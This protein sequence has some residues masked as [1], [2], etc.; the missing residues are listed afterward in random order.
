MLSPGS[1]RLAKQHSIPAMPVPVRAIVNS[2]LVP[3]TVRSLSCISSSTGKSSGSRCPTGAEP[4]A[5]NTLG[6]TDMG[7][8]P[9][10]IRG[11][12][13]LPSVIYLLL[14]PQALI[15]PQ[16]YPLTNLMPERQVSPAPPSNPTRNEQHTTPDAQTP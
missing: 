16:L 14:V 15:S 2:L 12:G 11:N 1:A 8:G 3:K 6:A 9:I 13:R 4:I 7:P 5:R 10:R